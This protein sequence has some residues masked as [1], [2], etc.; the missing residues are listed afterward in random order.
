MPTK[1]SPAK[2]APARKAA[3]K[4]A[5]AAPVAKKVKNPYR[6]DGKTYDL[7][8]DDVAVIADRTVRWVYSHSDLL[9]GVKRAWLPGNARATIRF[10]GPAV[11]RVLRSKGIKPQPLP[12]S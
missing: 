8:V 7:T 12:E 10:N 2:K 4:K 5:P 1:K 6:H 3:A 9:E 11:R